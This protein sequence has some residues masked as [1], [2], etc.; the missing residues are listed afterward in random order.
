VDSENEI[1]DIIINQLKHLG[2]CIKAYFNESPI[3][4]EKEKEAFSKGLEEIYANLNK[5]IDEEFIK[6]ELKVISEFEN[7]KEYA[8]YLSK[9]MK[10]WLSLIILATNYKNCAG[11]PLYQ[12]YK[13][14]FDESIVEYTK[15]EL[16]RLDKY[17]KQVS[18]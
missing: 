17:F 16:E 3:F 13:D 1:R 7:L 2:D 4:D 5:I 11:H 18:S 8:Q 15:N 10:G 9:T 14:E 6:D 12:Q